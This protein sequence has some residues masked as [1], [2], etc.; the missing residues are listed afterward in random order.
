M[1][2]FGSS[3]DTRVSVA[4]LILLYHNVEWETKYTLL[5]GIFLC[6]CQSTV[7]KD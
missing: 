7:T 6:I 1:G 2:Q 5:I 3:C 4:F